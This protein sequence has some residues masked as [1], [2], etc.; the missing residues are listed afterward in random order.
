MTQSAYAK[1][2]T[3]RRA[4][5]PPKG[6]PTPK[7]NEQGNARKQEN[8]RSRRLEWAV[9]AIIALALVVAL[10]VFGGDGGGASLHGV[11]VGGHGG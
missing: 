8:A 9:L 7:R 1:T 5:T 2:A 10:V 11:P 6:R 3:P 4:E